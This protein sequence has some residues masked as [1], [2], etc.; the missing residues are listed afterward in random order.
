MGFPVS[1]SAGTHAEEPAGA[2]SG[3]AFIGVHAD[4]LLIS[5][6]RRTVIQ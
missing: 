1:A 6:V 4:I 3:V 2:G 5:R